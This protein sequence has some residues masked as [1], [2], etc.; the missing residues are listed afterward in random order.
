LRALARRRHAPSHE[1]FVK[2]DLQAII[3]EALTNFSSPPTIYQSVITSV[4][5]P[6]LVQKAEASFN[7]SATKIASRLSTEFSTA[8]LKRRV[9]KLCRT[10]CTPM[11]ARNPA[12]KDPA[13]K[14]ESRLLRAAS[15]FRWT[16]PSRQLPPAISDRCRNWSEHSARR[17]APPARRSSGSSDGRL[18][19]PA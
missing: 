17:R 3:R 15:A 12:E 1:Q 8:V 18:V 11:E 6:R 4:S 2:S 5:A 14:C 16:G 10:V 13:E 7:Q 9:E 19:L